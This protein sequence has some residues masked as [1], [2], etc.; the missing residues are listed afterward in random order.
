MTKLYEMDNNPERRI[1]L[2][3]LLHYMDEHGTPITACPTISKQP[4]DLFKMYYSVK[5]RGGF[6]EVSK[7]RIP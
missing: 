4:L 3:K 7:V 5:E 1:F 2:D 6:L